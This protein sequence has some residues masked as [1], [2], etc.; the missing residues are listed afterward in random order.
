[1]SLGL[2]KDPVNIA[3]TVCDDGIGMPHPDSSGSFGRGHGIRNL[4]ERAQMTGGRM[5]LSPGSRGGTH[6]QM[7]WPLAVRD[8]QS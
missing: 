8:L 1:V 3:L 2:S 7:D 5:T 6:V 4:R